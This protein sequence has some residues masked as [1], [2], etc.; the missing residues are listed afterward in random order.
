MFEYEGYGYINN[1]PLIKNL[2]N[3]G[4]LVQISFGQIK[5]DEVSNLE[6]LNKRY[7]QV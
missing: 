3:L 7:L 1:L 4:W 6:L 5:I 2:I